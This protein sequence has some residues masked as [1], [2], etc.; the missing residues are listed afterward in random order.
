MYFNES[1]VTEEY[2]VDQCDNVYD[3]NGMFYDKWYNLTEDEKEIVKKNP[4]SY[5]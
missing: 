4:A 1:I 3:E 5:Y 2:R